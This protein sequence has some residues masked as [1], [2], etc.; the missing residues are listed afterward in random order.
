MRV[1]GSVTDLLVPPRLARPESVSAR[2]RKHCVSDR[3]RR[4]GE[5]RESISDGLRYFKIRQTGYHSS[6]LQWV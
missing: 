5:W 3:S 2:R 4:L 1:A 6:G